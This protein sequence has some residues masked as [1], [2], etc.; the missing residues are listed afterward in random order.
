MNGDPLDIAFAGIVRQAQMLR[1]GE[2]TAP[3]LTELYLERI[4]RL[5][6]KVNAFN[7]V[8]PES[9]RAEAAAAQQRLDAGES[10][11]LLGVPIAVKDNIDIEGHVTSI[12]TGGF[13]KPAAA[14]AEI[15]RRLRAAG[16][17]I[18]GTTNLPEFAMYAHFTASPTWG[19][20]RNPWNPERAPGGSSGGSAAAVAAGLVGAAVASDG[21]GSIRVPA[22]HC[23]LFGL[24]PQRGRVS[25][26][27]RAQ[28]WSGLSV[29]GSVTR[30]VA[31]SALF[32]DAVAG[33]VSGDGDIAMPP[34]MPYA[35]AAAED[36][37]KL[38][39]GVSM[40]PAIPGTIVDREVRDAVAAV[41]D[42]L[43]RLGH[44]VVDAKVRYPLLLPRFMPRYVT[45]IAED[46]TGADEGK[47]SRRSRQA[48][49]LGRSKL[50]QR[51]KQ[52]S[53]DQEDA[54][55]A[56]IEPVF[57]RNDV[58]LTPTIARPISSA[59]KW[60]GKGFFHSL[61][62]AGFYVAFSAFWNYTGQPA[63]SIPAGFT[64]DG[65]P[66]SAQ[67]VGPPDSEGLLL[68]L[69]AQIERERPW[70]DARPALAAH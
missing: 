12:G 69:A 1:D 39:I 43:S 35:Q 54:A 63:A 5:N 68:S 25:L 27:P 36:P 34:D 65:M 18:I 16:A 40:T 3:Q 2:I 23:G 44:E 59:G 52:W 60:L 49:K 4:E 51:M 14:D 46:A 31:D 70:T 66:L 29:E 62:T 61:P 8:F 64:T 20:T 7:A 67:L 30:G 17:V 21:G 9:A 11:P 28:N 48:I 24:K 55:R 38:R 13:S 32:L 15:V 33:N 37:P 26:M 42:L 6:P 45:G 57:E 47:L 50:A 53:I 19:V 56:K 41:G 10:A 58:L 22:A